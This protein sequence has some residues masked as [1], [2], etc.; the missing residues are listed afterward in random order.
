[1]SSTFRHVMPVDEGDDKPEA[2]MDL[3]KL[4]KHQRQQLVDAG[5]APLPQTCH[6]SLMHVSCE[7]VGGFKL[8]TRSCASNSASSWSTEVQERGF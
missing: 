2:V 3:K 1:M 5:A 8:T 7:M 4:R 6:P